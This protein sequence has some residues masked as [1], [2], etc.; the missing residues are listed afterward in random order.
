MQVSLLVGHSQLGPS[1]PLSHTQAPLEQR[2]R[3]VVRAGISWAPVLCHP[4]P[5]LWLPR[6]LWGAQGMQALHS[7][8]PARCRSRVPAPITGHPTPVPVPPVQDTSL[9]HSGGALTVAEE[10]GGARA[11][12]DIELAEGAV[13]AQD[14]VLGVALALPAQAL[15]PARARLHIPGADAGFVVGG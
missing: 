5:C 14:L 9:C 1:Q 12:Q 3:S 2:P 11:L 8:L 10:A 6:C 13:E 7:I 15:A 4:Q